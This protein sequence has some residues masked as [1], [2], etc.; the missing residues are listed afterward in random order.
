MRAGFIG[1]PC[2]RSAARI[3]GIDEWRD[4]LVILHQ[5]VEALEH[6]VL[7]RRIGHHLIARNGARA[8]EVLTRPGRRGHV[9]HPGGD[10][11]RL[12]HAVDEDPAVTRVLVGPG[13][14]DQRD[15]DVAVI[16]GVLDQGEFEAH[17]ALLAVVEDAGG[18]RVGAVA[19]AG[20]DPGFCFEVL[21][22]VCGFHRVLLF[23]FSKP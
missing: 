8:G 13:A 9:L 14:G 6:P 3:L 1:A 12:R 4:I 11:I 23:G 17:L 7:G 5:V 10:A 15:P 22:R 18:D 2:C 19:A 21:D 16:V 20:A